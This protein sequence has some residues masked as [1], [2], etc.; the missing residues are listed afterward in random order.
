MYKQTD[1]LY[2]NNNKYIIF[3]QLNFLLRIIFTIY[4]INFQFSS[5]KI[6]R[7]LLKLKLKLIFT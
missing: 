3:Q 7:I 1:L 6:N 5:Y 2:S 4:F